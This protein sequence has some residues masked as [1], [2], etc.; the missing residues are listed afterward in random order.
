MSTRPP[1]AEPA[2]ACLDDLTI[3][4]LADGTLADAA[5]AAALQHLATCAACRERVARVSDLL[6]DP[7]VEQEIRALETQSAPASPRSRWIRIAAGVAAAALVVLAVRSTRTLLQQDLRLRE[8]P[9][10]LISSPTLLQPT[11]TVAR[12]DTLR[13]GAVPRATQYRVT[14]FSQEGATVWETSTSDTVVAIGAGVRL[15]AG[16]VYYW[17]VEARTDW[18]R[19][20]ASELIEI[21]IGGDR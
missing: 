4:A 8:T 16:A 9:V 20:T 17:K 19:W 6:H 2:L 3:A 18:N 10:T 15:I 1:E 7:A 13:W 5:R 14:L 21:R 11:G 12:V